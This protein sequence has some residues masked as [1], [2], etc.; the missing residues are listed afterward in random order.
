M[1]VIEK[2]I[3][4]IDVIIRDYALD[5]TKIRE[6]QDGREK[7]SIFYKKYANLFSDNRIIQELKKYMYRRNLTP[8]ENER[9]NYL[10]EISKKIVMSISH[11]KFKVLL[12]LYEYTTADLQNGDEKAKEF[13]NQFYQELLECFEIE[14]KI[15]A[16]IVIPIWK[17]YLNSVDGEFSQG[18][19]FAYLL[20]SSDKFINLPGSYGYQSEKKDEID[21]C[22]KTEF[23][24]AS[25]ITDKEMETGNTN[26]GILIKIKNKTILAA[27]PSDCGTV[28]SNVKGA[29][30]VKASNNGYFVSIGLPGFSIPVSKL[31]TPKEIESKAMQSSIHN[32]GEILNAGKWIIPIYTEVVVDKDDF[33]L[34]GIFFKTT[35]CDINIQDYL[36]AKQME[37][38]YGKKLRIVNQSVNREKNNLSPYTQ[39]EKERFNNQLAFYMSED[40]YQMFEQSPVLY[41][42]LFRLYY[43]EV[44]EGAGFKGETKAKAE[45]AILK[46]V[47]HL[48]S[49]IQCN[50][51]ED[52]NVIKLD[53]IMSAFLDSDQLPKCRYEPEVKWG[54]AT[55]TKNEIG[56]EFAMSIPDDLKKRVERILNS[57]V[58]LERGEING[59]Y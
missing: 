13:Y 36:V 4:D 51:L 14:D 56:R 45:T 39:E 12:P 42:N 52:S 34:D 22:N 3:E 37:M 48:D 7:V 5:S 55:V 15:Q 19:A 20:H 46:V 54:F 40:N 49:V 35:G 32:T 47:E 53:E 29:N 59:K 44:I 26:V 18:D 10:Q 9:A 57:K 27:S 38:Y 6:L 16:D 2:M 58:I 43:Q 28:E 23:I 1:V 33:E 11:N 41:R 17:D 8:E 25:L 31:G 50:G 30:N 24:S 21:A